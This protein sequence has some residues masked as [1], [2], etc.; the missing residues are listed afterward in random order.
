MITDISKKVSKITVDG[1]VMELKQPALSEK[2]ITEN[3][4]YLPSD[5]GVDGYSKVIVDVGETPSGE[6]QP[7]EDMKWA[8]QVCE[9]D[10]QEGFTYKVL[11]MISDGYV[12]TDI[13]VPSGGAVKT[14]DGGYYTADAKHTW[15]DTNAR[16]ATSH[17]NMKLRWLI[18]YYTSEKPSITLLKDV[19]YACFDGVKFGTIFSDKKMLE[20]FDIIN[21]AD[22]SSGLTNMTGMFQHCVSLQTIPLLNT[23]KVTN[24]SDMFYYCRSIKTI[25]LLDTR[26]VTR[27]NYMFYICSLLQTIPLLNTSKVTNMSDMFGA[28]YSLQTIPQ[29]DT[30]NVTHM[31][32]MFVNCYTLQ[33]IP[34]LDTSKVTNMSGMFNTCS[35]LQLIPLLNTS[36]ATDMS[37][38][39]VNCSVLRTIPLLNTSNVTDMS[40][41]FNSCSSL[42]TIPQLDTSS[43]TNMSSMFNSCSVLQTIPL[44][45]TSSVTDMS[46]MFYY[47]SSLQ[48]IPQ[49]DTSS[50]TNMR[51][52]FNSCSYLEFLTMTNIKVSFNINASTKLSQETLEALID[53][54]ADLTGQTAQTFTMG[55]TN[56]AKV[57]QEKKDLATARNWNLN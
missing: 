21:G 28:C 18:Y 12:Y 52:M 5:D 10:V 13:V 3:G 8:K 44:L 19:M 57:S 4:E 33:T 9:N 48:T 35:S 42:Q 56:L 27:M 20:Y 34:Q 14:S 43:A 2:I 51:S 15:D 54:L 7:N 50:V 16:V 24:M 55:S 40:G 29:L 32:G 17:T 46:N 31:D 23:S 49:L 45:D 38:M 39:F 1:E 6:W 11:Q 41:M 53:N 47:C 22:L 25:P 26:N 30:S 36:N 37:S